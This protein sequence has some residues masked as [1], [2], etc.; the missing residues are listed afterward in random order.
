MA[1]RKGQPN[2]GEIKT[3]NFIGVDT[4]R[5]ERVT[6]EPE[7]LRSDAPDILTL[8]I[9]IIVLAAL[10]VMSFVLPK[11]EISLI[12]NRP[13]EKAP[14]FSAKALTSGEFTDAF[15]RYYADTFPWREKMIEMSTDF[16]RVSG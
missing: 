14:G 2:I 11:P 15:S 12:E 16:N 7:R 1:K 4:L 8:M 9:L 3:V 6:D 13:L 5:E 10:G